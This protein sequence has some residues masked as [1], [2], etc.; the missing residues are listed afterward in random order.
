[1]ISDYSSSTKYPWKVLNEMY[2]SH[3]WDI[4]FNI[5]VTIRKAV[6]VKITCVPAALNLFHF[7]EFWSL[8]YATCTRFLEMLLAI[9]YTNTAN[10]E[11][12]CDRRYNWQSANRSLSHFWLYMTTLNGLMDIISPTIDWGSTTEPIEQI[13][14]VSTNYRSD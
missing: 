11:Y 12:V 4:K 8:F 2:G 13:Y 10:H 6:Q 14:N 3:L 5:N 1:M 7:I 9:I